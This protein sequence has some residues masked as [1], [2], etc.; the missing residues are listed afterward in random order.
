MD[1]GHEWWYVQKTLT[2]IS[3]FEHFRWVIYS[4]SKLAWVNSS[5]VS[6]VTHEV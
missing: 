2:H 5:G 4:L 6:Y 1:V 3:T